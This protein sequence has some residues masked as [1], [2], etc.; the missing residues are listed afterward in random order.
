VEYP[1]EQTMQHI[2]DRL[3]GCKLLGVREE[4]EVHSP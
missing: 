3:H 1:S 2:L 4:G